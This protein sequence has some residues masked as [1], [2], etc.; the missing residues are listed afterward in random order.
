MNL[1][2]A[3]RNR[4]TEKIEGN[5][6]LQFAFTC[7][8][9]ASVVMEGFS[10]KSMANG[11]N[12]S[13]FNSLIGLKFHEIFFVVPEEWSL[14]LDTKKKD[15]IISYKEHINIPSDKISIFKQKKASEKW[16]IISNGR[17]FTQ[18]NSKIIR[19]M[20]EKVSADVIS[21]N[22]DPQ[23]L[24]EREKVRLTMEGNIAGFRRMY[25]D[26]AEYSP[27]PNDWPAHL[28]IKAEILNKI[29]TENSLPVSFPNI[30][31]TCTEKNIKVRGVDVGGIA[32]DLDSEFGL[33]QFCRMMLKNQNESFRNES[34]IPKNHNIKLIGKV[35]LGKNI[36]IGS[37]T[38]IIGSSIIGDDVIIDEGSLI[39]SSI[40]GSNTFIHRENPIQNRIQGGQYEQQPLRKNITYIRSDYTDLKKSNLNK[41]RNWSVFSYA[42]LIKRIADIFVSI[43]V[44]T[45]FI[46]LL[47]FIAGAIKLT[48]PG[49]IFYRDKRQGL[50]GREFH[51]LKF[52]TMI[53][54]ASKI[55]EN[56]RFVS[57]VD[58]P[59]FK[60]DDDP[61]INLVGKF[62]R[63]TYIDEIPQFFNVLLGQ[64]SVV[65]PRPSPE[66]EN[67]LCPFW[68]DARL[69]VKPG[70]TGLWQICRTR[71]PMKDFQE[72]IKYDIEYVKN[73]SM[74]RDLEICWKTAKKM[75]DNFISQF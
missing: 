8:P 4:G 29:I 57:Q 16:F 65:G 3:H 73:L 17:F 7:N 40:I 2:I 54:G 12:V 36:Q 25:S 60:I 61:R 64:M 66:S 75:I 31:E 63:E 1:I 44:L 74:K 53:P 27:V 72:W 34:S 24:S 23:L 48:S 19:H 39:N 6:F 26:S 5:H 50:H 69:S 49:P 58:G 70:I 9:V 51:C 10:K 30:M 46:P 71:R 41:F 14:P 32:L 22:V 52:R 38:T 37:K 59:Q 67:T 11:D 35:L 45:L 13:I 15:N 33:L 21:I 18:I 42:R 20:L 28:F 55:Q 43:I 47:P 56:L 62:L 68:R